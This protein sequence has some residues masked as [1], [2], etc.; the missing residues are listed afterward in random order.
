MTGSAGKS[1]Q[2]AGQVSLMISPM[3]FGSVPVAPGLKM[4]P[5]SGRPRCPGSRRCACRRRRPRNTRREAGEEKCWLWL[6]F[7]RSEGWAVSR[8]R[9]LEE[10]SKSDA[11]SNDVSEGAPVEQMPGFGQKPSAMGH[12]PRDRRDRS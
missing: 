4:T 9:D 10:Q 5:S 8:P 6:S 7:R 3:M 1:L 11:E 12:G 2:F